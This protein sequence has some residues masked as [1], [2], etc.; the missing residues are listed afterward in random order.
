MRTVADLSSQRVFF[1]PGRFDFFGNLELPLCCGC[2]PRQVF[3]GYEE[4]C[5]AGACS[6]I[7][8]FALEGL[9]LKYGGRSRAS[10]S[11]QGPTADGRIKP[12]LIAPGQDIVSARAQGPDARHYNDFN[13]SAGTTLT[14]ETP[15]PF[16]VPVDFSGNPSIFVTF[17][18][19]TLVRTLTITARAATATGTYEIFFVTNA[20]ERPAPVVFTVT[21]PF[22]T[23]RTFPLPVDYAFAAGTTV[24]IHL[25]IPE[26]IP[27]GTLE[28]FGD[29][30]QRK[31]DTCFGSVT[32]SF[33][34][35]FATQR[36]GGLAF[37]GTMSGT[38]MA[39]PH[40]AG[41]A[42]VVEQY[43]A[44]GFYPSGAPVAANAFNASAALV[45]A[46]LL[47]SASALA[48]NDVAA[49]FS[50]AL[51]PNVVPPLSA[52]ALYAIGG[53]GVPSLPRVLSVASLGSASRASGALPWLLVPGRAPP[54][55]G[56]DPTLRHGE[57][58]VF[59]VDVQPA[60]GATSSPPFSAMLVWTD[61][62]ASPLA[63][64]ALVNDLDLE[65]TP[66]GSFTRLGNNNASSPQQL[67]DSR[68][69]AEKVEL[70]LPAA[71]LSA[72][73]AR[74]QP[75]YTV[76]VR[77]AAVPVGAAQ[78]YALV[79]TG[80]RVTLAAAGTCA[81]P[82]AP[83]PS[84]TPAPTPTP[85]PTP[86][87]AAAA[88]PA[89]LG[90]PATAAIATLGAALAAAGA[91]GIYLFMRARKAEAELLLGEMTAIN[92]ARRSRDKARAQPAAAATPPAPWRPPPPRA[93]PPPPP[94]DE[95]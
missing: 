78:A 56:T 1:V 30:A 28:L 47:N 43:F 88:A 5:T 31:H 61:P 87:G 42:T 95:D 14:G 70:P 16:Q 50:Q 44:T 4:M 40:V 94:A 48:Y 8:P 76:V 9:Y 36:A 63:A 19:P 90:A 84:P 25:Y 52:A 34:L 83:S 46:T 32:A 49:I 82:A 73:G 68:N 65:V 62:A 33:Q 75:P 69:N 71:T 89:E 27:G 91:A 79:V 41:L 85:S 26:D 24:A 3:E 21:E 35:T 80:P 51:Y 20:T 10:T 22:V 54:P 13:C 12:D 23:T 86:P 58:T 64:F 74:I 15:W 59:C 2:T 72:A 93:P 37:T 55:N 18:E 39:A 57:A 60:A 77:A 6:F 7:H 66:P 45:K 29:I 67:R 11:S 92:P 17:R 38:S 81:D 53:F